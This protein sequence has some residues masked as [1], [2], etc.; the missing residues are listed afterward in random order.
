[1]TDTD[2]KEEWKKMMA[3]EFQQLE[4]HSTWGTGTNLQCKD[5]DPTFDIGTMLQAISRW[6]DQEAQGAYLCAR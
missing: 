6:G 1:M 5:K 4:E 2:N 3:Q